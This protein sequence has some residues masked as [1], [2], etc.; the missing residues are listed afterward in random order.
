MSGSG[1]SGAVARAAQALAF[2]LL[3]TGCLYQFRGGNFPEYIR[4]LSVDPVE[5]GTPRLEVTGELNEQ[6]TRTLAPA[7]GVRAAS[8][9]V[10]DAVV[11]VKVLRYE[12]NAPNYR[13]GAAGQRTEVLQRQVEITAQ[14]QIVDRVNNQIFWEDSSVRA[15]GQF[16]EQS[17]TE[18]VGRT[19]AIKL[20][21]QK[22]IDGAQSNW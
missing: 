18:E 10:A 13:P 7:L 20:L 9:D 2:V 19:E 3:C 16:L 6:L 22:I 4:T 15:D 8:S 11:R 14:V 1:A 21:V 12:V 5:N 17:E